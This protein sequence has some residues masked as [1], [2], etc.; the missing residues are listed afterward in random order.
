MKIG[1]GAARLWSRMAGCTDIGGKSGVNVVKIISYG[2][3]CTSRRYMQAPSKYR[4][5]LG[6]P[7]PCYVLDFQKEKGYMMCMAS[8]TMG[9]KIIRVEFREGGA[10]LIFAR[11]P[12]LK[13]LLVSE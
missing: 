13:G 11:S 3:L 12:D 2:T 5:L 7:L 10:G 8:T 4:I 9:A 1:A 6:K